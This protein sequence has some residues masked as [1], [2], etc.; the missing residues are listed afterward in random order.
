MSLMKMG[1]CTHMVVASFVVLIFRLYVDGELWQER[2]LQ[3]NRP[4]NNESVKES[5]NLDVG[6]LTLILHY[7]STLQMD[8]ETTAHT[9]THTHTHTHTDTDTH[10]HTHTHTRIFLWLSGINKVKAPTLDLRQV[11]IA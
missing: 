9:W 1:C 8:A 11:S 4:K 3:G 6:R 5:W 2:T 10:T 7:V